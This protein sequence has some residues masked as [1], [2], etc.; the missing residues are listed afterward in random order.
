MY[1][2]P[3][4]HTLLKMQETTPGILNRRDPDMWQRFNEVHQSIGKI[5]ITAVKGLTLDEL[6]EQLKKFSDMIS[7]LGSYC[8]VVETLGSMSRHKSSEWV[9]WNTIKISMNLPDAAIVV[10]DTYWRLLNSKELKES[11]GGLEYAV[12]IKGIRAFVH[13]DDVAYSGTQKIGIITRFDYWIR[14]L[15]SD[16]P[17]DGDTV[18]KVYIS[19][20]TPRAYTSLL[21][22][23]VT[24][25]RFRVKVYVGAVLDVDSKTVFT[26]WKIPN[27]LSFNEDYGDKMRDAWSNRF[28]LT[29]HEPYKQAPEER[30]RCLG[31][32]RS[33][34]SGVTF[35]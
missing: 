7:N 28:P 2:A 8:W 11:F 33:P 34:M 13:V 32:E 27:G 29:L 5:K 4:M 16:A 18:F 26:E 10:T 31:N 9:G 15:Y 12:R 19:F 23:V 1:S 22:C 21:E 14:S 35:Y 6:I 24:K 25:G 20:A 17:F 3:D 30:T